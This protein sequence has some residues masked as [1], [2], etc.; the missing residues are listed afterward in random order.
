MWFM[1]QAGRYLPEYRAVRAKFPDF[2]AFCFSPEAATDVTL[3]PVERFG[4][5]AAIIFADILTIPHVMGHPVHFTAGEGP[6]VAPLTTTKQVAAM[7]DYLA[8]VPGLLAPVGATVAS[9]RKALGPDK[10]VIGFSGGPFTLA[11]YMLDSKPSQGIPNTLRFMQEHPRSFTRLLDTLTLACV[12]YLA[13][14]IEAGADAV[15]IFDSWAAAAPAEHWK[16]CV[17]VPLVTLGRLL[18]ERHPETPV[19]LFPRLATKQQLLALRA[20]A[21]SAFDAVSLSTETDLVWASKTLQPF[22]AIQGNLDP[23]LFTLD[24]PDAALAATKQALAVAANQPGYVVN[25]GHGFTPDTKPDTLQ[26]V[27]DTIRAYA[28]D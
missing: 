8:D 3:Q 9:T 12:S 23:R 10:A 5:D 21:P 13:M 4:L 25:L 19:I 17:L 11:C 20:H 15:Q 6:R 24:S 7:Q 14:Q 2:M 1:R 28:N 26:L 18:K 22:H 27:A 16:T